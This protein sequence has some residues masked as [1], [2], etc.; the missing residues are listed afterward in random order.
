MMAFPKSVFRC[1]GEIVEIGL[2]DDDVL[3]GSAVR[4][5]IAWPLALHRGK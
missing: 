2:N 4:T 3:G 1:R 5:L